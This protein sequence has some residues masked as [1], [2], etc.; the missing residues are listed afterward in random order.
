M[1][2]DASSFFSLDK[3]FR[4][5]R[6]ERSMALSYA[7]IFNVRVG[8]MFHSAMNANAMIK[9][10]I[11][12]GANWKQFTTQILYWYRRTRFTICSSPS[13]IILWAIISIYTSDSVSLP[14]NF[15]RDKRKKESFGA[16]KLR[17]TKTIS[18]RN[19]FIPKKHRSNPQGL[20]FENSSWLHMWRT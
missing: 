20:I 16:P 2:D 5:G 12:Q 9:A 8:N 19:C 13:K 11:G 7:P 15:T 18:S 10:F 1:F 6:D 17:T 3:N 4:E 14:Q